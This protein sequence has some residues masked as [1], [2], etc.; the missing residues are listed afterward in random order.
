MSEHSATT[1]SG[2]Q[3]MAG[4]RVLVIGLGRFGGGVGVTRWLVSQGARVTVTDLASAEALADSV[5]AIADLG[6]EYRL[7]G[8]DLNDLE[9]VDLVVVNPAVDKKR[10]PFFQ[11]VIRRGIPWTTEINLFC[12]RCPAPI[13]GVTGSYGKSTTSAM[14]AHALRIWGETDE[15]PYGKIHLGGNIGGSLLTDL[16]R[17][18]PAD[19]VVLEF[20][21]AQLEDLPRIHWAPPIAVILNLCPHHLDRYGDFA[22]YAAAKL[23][24]CRDPNRASQVF[25]GD[26]DEAAEMMLPRWLRDRPGRLR[27]I[28]AP[29]PPIKLRIPGQH[30]QANAAAVLA[31][32]TYLGARD[33]LIREALHSFAGLSHRLEHVRT[34]NAVDYFNDSKSTSP[35]SVL[36]AVHA[37]VQRMVVIVGGERKN[38]PLDAWAE[39]M[40]Q[41]A[42]AVICTGESG[43]AFAAAVRAADIEGRV[44]T[45][46]AASLDEAVRLARS[47]ARDGDVVLFSPGAPSFDQYANFA[48]RGQHFQEIVQSL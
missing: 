39:Q 7:G 25:I 19:L 42:K 18:R 35:A 2:P 46:E 31:V 32:G 22:G 13:V 34:L 20:S 5:R 1:G 36:A 23:N 44:A 15:G 45:R 10:S 30:N 27:R 6:V 21:N 3:E 33:S 28:A 4:R 9:G 16:D 38:T 47:H 40:V 43:P 8:H 17:V 12:Q 48:E 37:L 11:E 14:L 41:R 24:I 26:V 29:N